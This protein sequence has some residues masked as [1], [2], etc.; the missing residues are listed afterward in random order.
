MLNKNMPSSANN[1]LE[2]GRWDPKVI[3]NYII[4]QDFSLRLSAF[5][6]L[7]MGN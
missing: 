4:G 6:M 7:V 2:I 1:I 5:A 3:K